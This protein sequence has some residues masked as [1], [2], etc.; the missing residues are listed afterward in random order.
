ML[1]WMYYVK[2]KTPQ[3]DYVLWEDP[4]DTQFTKGP[5]KALMRQSTAS[6]SPV[7]PLFYR[8]WIMIG[9]TITE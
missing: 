4:E 6:K 9:E 1:K 5:R 3:D 7:M 2:P 8:P